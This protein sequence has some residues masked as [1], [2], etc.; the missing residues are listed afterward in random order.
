MPQRARI[1]RILA[2]A[3]HGRRVIDEREVA[4][5]QAA[6]ELRERAGA[7]IGR[8]VTQRVTVLVEAIQ[9][10]R[11]DARHFAFDEVHATLLAAAGIADGV[12][13]RGARN[14]GAHVQAVVRETRVVRERLHSGHPPD[15]SGTVVQTRMPAAIVAA[16]ERFG[17]GGR[18]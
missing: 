18:R 9:N 12:V 14:A 4:V 3:D 1:F 15:I 8:G 2:R 16:Q 17:I 13:V 5:R 6:Q 7:V 11:R 10:V